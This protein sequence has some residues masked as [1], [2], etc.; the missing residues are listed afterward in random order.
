MANIIKG[1][2]T[3]GFFIDMLTRDIRLDRA[4]IDL[5]DNSIDGAK[6]IKQEDYSGLEVDIR[7][8]ED[9]FV[10]SDNCGGFTL[11][12]A[13]NYAFRFGRPIEAKFVDNSI[14]RFG[15][16]MKRAL[17]KIGRHFTVESKNKN[18]HF[19]V[20][21]DVS[22][23]LTKPNDWNFTYVEKEDI[24]VDKSLL[25]EKDGT[26][27]VV[28]DLYE[29]ISSRFV[30]NAFKNELEKELSI[31]LSYSILKKLSV[32][33]NGK[34]IIRKDISFI[35]SDTLK[36]LYKQL[37][38]DGVTVKIYAG[39]GEP[40]PSEAGWYIFCNDRLVLEAD[41]SYTTG[42]KENKED[43]SSIIKYHNK[44]AMFRGVIFFESVDS[45]KL[46]MTTTKTGID[47]DHNIYKFTR[48]EIL[49]AMRQVTNFLNK[50]ED[51]DIRADLIANAS[52]VN[53]TELNEKT[54]NYSNVF[55]YPVLDKSNKD[56]KFVSITYKR[57][58][59][60]VEKLKDFLNVSTSKDVGEKTFDFFVQTY[61]KEI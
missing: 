30:E 44:Q 36:P 52:M 34:K 19:L 25:G 12:T 26:V 58:K 45:S 41:K 6:L 4:I 37:H 5:V 43:D 24:P 49:I 15:V 32:T 60:F 16:G 1:D 14:G 61:E 9:K 57:E 53:I 23:W 21:V 50:I 59:V 29:N 54:Q 2:P 31:A 27:I 22:S 20:E 51:K 38:R 7:V 17:F 8:E 33:L 13:I 39:I 56:N 55:T 11:N 3:K 42:W 18:D 40:I 10:I 46:P 48:P 47:F 28:T 35:E